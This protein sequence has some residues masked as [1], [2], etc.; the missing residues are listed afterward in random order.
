MTVRTCELSVE[1]KQADSYEVTVTNPSD[2]VA[3]MIRLTAKDAKGNLVCPAY[4]SDN[5]LTLAPGESRNITCRMPS[6]AK[7]AKVT[8]QAE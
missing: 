2:K 7:D 4:W 6:L 8:I 5:Y 3:F 1:K